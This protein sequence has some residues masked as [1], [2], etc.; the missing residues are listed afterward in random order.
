MHTDTLRISTTVHTITYMQIVPVRSVHCASSRDYDYCVTQ[1]K[2]QYSLIQCTTAE[3]SASSVSAHAHNG[4]ALLSD[5][6]CYVIR[7]MRSGN[8]HTLTYCIAAHISTA[9]KTARL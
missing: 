1:L 2:M 6:V 4:S 5:A 9:P 7:G 3:Y 8:T